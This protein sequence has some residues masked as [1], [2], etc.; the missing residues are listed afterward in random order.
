M[1]PL[2]KK[3]IRDLRA[4]K[5][6]MISL[7]IVVS[8]G[9]MLYSGI[10]ATF[11]N[12]S[13]ASTAYYREYR[14]AD[15]W[16]NVVSAPSTILSVLED[17]PEILKAEGRL[18]TDLSIT[19]SGV[20]GTVRVQ[21]LPDHNQQ[22]LNDVKLIS[23]TYFSAS[24]SQQVLVEEEYFKAHQLTLGSIITP[25]YQGKPVKLRVVGVVKSPEYIY[26][27]KDGSE[28]MPDPLRFGILYVKESFGHALL[29]T[30]GNYNQIVLSLVP[31][32]SLPAL[33]TKLEKWLKP[34]GL[35]S[36]FERDKQISHA[37][38]SEEMKGLKSVSGAFPSVFLTV[39][40][41]I[42]YLMM[43]RMVEQQRTQIG[44]LKAFGYSDVNILFHYL[45]YALFVS[46]IGSAIGALTGVY[47]GQGMTLMENAYFHLPL[48]R[49][50]LYPELV[51]PATALTLFFCLIASWKACQNAFRLSPSAALRP[52]SPPI[53]KSILLERWSA[54]WKR[55]NFSWKMVLRNLFR[56][57]KRTAMT[58]TG[59]VFGAALLIV[60]MGMMDSVN[61]LIDSQY[62]TQ[63]NYDLKV[64]LNRLIPKSD[65]TVFSTLDHVQR[66]EPLLETGVTLQNGAKKKTVALIGLSTDAQMIRLL[67]EKNEPVPLPISGLVIPKK[68]TD[69]LNLET[70]A[71]VKLTPLIPNGKSKTVF[72]SGTV[73]Q[74]LGL[75]AYGT[76]E[77]T[78]KL[79]GEEAVAN[80]FVLRLDDLSAS[81]SVKKH[82]IQWKQVAS[83]TS[84]SDAKENLDENIGLMTASISILILLSGVL[85][86]S[87]I[88]NVSTI[89]I[90]E[91]QR[92][93]ATLKV[94]GFK[95]NEIRQVIFYENYLI[96][97]ISGV[98]SLP[99]GLLL[100]RLM[101][102]LYQTDAYSFVFIVTPGSYL[103]TLL[104]TAVFA[105]F[106][107]VLLVR[108]INR[109][110]MVAVLKNIE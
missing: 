75:S 12:L 107:N 106:S 60:S 85:S 47:L 30:G 16:I 65:W 94:M 40:G 44:V 84:K 24:S 41:I 37:M 76:L 66:A 23:G 102:A 10:N 74:F 83:V 95:D 105:W 70:P 51:I 88:Y 11:L 27:L 103:I 58:M 31:E 32:T 36:H 78:S 82:L 19:Q 38:L 87:V 52:K 53:G 8:L 50:R 71:P 7:M 15:Y 101:M 6:Q 77:T 22:V 86:T 92:E 108:K 73:V 17:S 69:D 72:L 25:S 63:M 55:L 62:D 57:K 35:K 43:G 96:T 81:E 29:G 34:Y 3:M 110:D 90:F 59:I 9:V 14:F 91:R 64:T 2:T 93:L 5:G 26:T 39:A 49:M 28:L 100:G 61:Y 21:T 20:N 13:S 99:L 33:S 56:Y 46:V 80:A 109:L 18:S 1:R 68:L 45:S 98:L 89:N 79:L 42:L 54:F 4:T 67:N 104:L 97:A 48:E